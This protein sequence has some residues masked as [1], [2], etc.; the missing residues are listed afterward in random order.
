MRDRACEIRFPDLT[1][2]FHRVRDLSNETPFAIPI[3]TSSLISLD[4]RTLRSRTRDIEGAI[5]AAARLR[6]SARPGNQREYAGSRIALYRLVTACVVISLHARY[7]S[8]ARDALSIYIAING[9]VAAVKADSLGAISTLRAPAPAIPRRPT[10][11]ARSRAFPLARLSPVTKRTSFS[12]FTRN[13][14][15]A[16]HRG[17]TRVEQLLPLLLFVC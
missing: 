7:R 11:P 10:C 5:Y 15:A 9:D 16:S 17:R 13:S 6:T 14:C 3:V 8:R 2:R 1:P 12:P 4:A